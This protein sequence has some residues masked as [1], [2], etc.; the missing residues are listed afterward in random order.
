[1]KHPALLLVALASAVPGMFAQ[2]GGQ[3]PPPTTPQAMPNPRAPEHD[4]LKE[5]TGTWDCVIRSTV[6]GKSEPVESKATEI[7][8]PVNKGLFVR[9]AFRGTMDGKPVEGLWLVGFDPFRRTYTAVWVDSL[10]SGAAT[11]DGTYDAAKKTWEW[12]GRSSHGELHSTVVFQDADNSVETCTCRDAEGRVVKTEI[13]RKRNERGAPT[14]ES[15]MPPVRTSP[16]DLPAELQPLQAQIGEW[17][18]TTK[19]TMPGQ[20]VVEENGNETVRWICSGRWQWS[21]FN[22]VLMGQPFEGHGITGYDAKTKKYVTFWIDSST[23]T[24]ASAEGT[25]DAASK[26]FTYTGN[27]VDP[28]GKQKPFQQTLVQKDDDTRV[29][30]LT[31]K[32]DKG[33]EVKLVIESKRWSKAR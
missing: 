32:D 10:D 25:Y 7:I 24:I 1:M 4:V 27:G 15:A 33:A 18:A 21:D 20:A 30:T 6:P 5:W 29:L 31:N 9:S 19:M 8:G 16:K 11:M 13:V 2:E 28:Q 12:R 22:G 3:K 23:G 26:T 14:V 17:G